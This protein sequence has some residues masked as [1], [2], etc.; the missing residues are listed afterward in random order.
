MV[1]IYCKKWRI[2]CKDKNNNARIN[3]FIKS[4][5]TQSPTENSGATELPPI[6][7]SF[8]YLESSG[9]NKGDNTYVKLIRTDII[10]IT[11]ISIY[12]NRFSISD[13]NL[14]AMPR[15]RI[16]ILLENGN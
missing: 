11:S 3:N 1:F 8:M 10:Q 5:K 14:R 13:E 9:N 6:G 2:V 16:Q 7:N 15:F 12:Y 4:T